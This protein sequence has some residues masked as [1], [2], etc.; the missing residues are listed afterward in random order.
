MVVTVSAAAAQQPE[1]ATDDK[2]VNAPAPAPPIPDEQSTIVEEARQWADDNKLVER[3][4]GTVDGWYPR[5]GGIRRGSGVAGGVGYRMHAGNVLID[6]SAAISVRN[7]QAFD[8]HV[9]WLESRSHRAQLWTDY[10]YDDLPQERY[11]G[12]GIDTIRDA[13]ASYGLRNNTVTLRG[14]LRPAARL[15][16]TGQI[17]YMHPR[18]RRGNDDQYP[19]ALE[20]FTEADA[21]SLLSQ[22]AFVQ[23]QVNADLDLRDVP[24]NARSGGVYHL[25]FG[26]WDARDRDQYD[27]RRIDATAA[28]YVP[29]TAD[30]RHVIVGRLGVMAASADAGARVPF[31]FLPYVGGRDTV[32]SFVEYRFSG[33]DALWYGAEYMWNWRPFVSL[34]AFTD[35]GRVARTW[36]DL[37]SGDTKQGYGFSVLGHTS[38]QTFARL[39][40]GFGGGEGWRFWVAFGGF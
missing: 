34:A 24:G 38:K 19:P 9:M 37:W 26:R 40:V 14:V 36:D 22:P 11:F 35:R 15:Q 13:R 7:Y 12:E 6:L 10:A 39:D 4:A 8:A 33:D 23:T 25:G 30:K 1:P 21:P 31:Y 2:R 3:M 5:I 17:G 18:L 20:A 32:R 16:L 29:L 28:Q 27:F